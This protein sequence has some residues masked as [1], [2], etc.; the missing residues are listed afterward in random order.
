MCVTME[1]NEVIYQVKSLS[2]CNVYI[3]C[4]DETMHQVSKR[5]ILSHRLLDSVRRM[6]VI[7]IVGHGIMI[8]DT[9]LRNY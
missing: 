3:L 1:S 4:P 9:L 6:N 5:V 2:N 7:H 8:Y